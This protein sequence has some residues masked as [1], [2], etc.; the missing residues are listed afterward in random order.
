MSLILWRNILSNLF[1]P[2]CLHFPV[3]E[4]QSVQAWRSSLNMINSRVHGALHASV[5][6][7]KRRRKQRGIRYTQKFDWQKWLLCDNDLRCR[8]H[9]IKIFSSDL[10]ALSRRLLM[11]NSNLEHF[12]GVHMLYDLKKK[13]LRLN[14]SW[15]ISF[16]SLLWNIA[17]YLTHC[18]IWQ[19]QIDMLWTHNRIGIITYSDVI[20]ACR[21]ELCWLHE[22]NVLHAAYKI[23]CSTVDNWP[24]FKIKLAG[25]NQNYWTNT[26]IPL[27]LLC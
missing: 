13:T 6:H 20:H 4:F 14:L 16:L 8:S 18:Y 27:I 26:M 15:I 2:N 3:R 12:N 9:K 10:V 24:F 17:C 19:V 21:L 25:S 23:W 7:F 11:I 5:W 22:I 1:L